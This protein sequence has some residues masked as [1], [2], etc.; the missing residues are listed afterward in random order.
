MEVRVGL[1]E[2]TLEGLKEAVEDLGGYFD[3]EGATKHGH[4]TIETVFPDME[5]EAILDQ[6]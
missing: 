1:S 5:L 4:A 3:R 6:E 2:V